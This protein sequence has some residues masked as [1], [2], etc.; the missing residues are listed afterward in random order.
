MLLTEV[1]SSPIAKWAIVQVNE[2]PENP[3][4]DEDFRLTVS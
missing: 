4:D 1:R 2:D 3:D